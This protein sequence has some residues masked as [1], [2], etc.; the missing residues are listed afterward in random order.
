MVALSFGMVFLCS[1]VVVAVD[2]ATDATI[3]LIMQDTI[4]VLVLILYKELR[5]SLLHLDR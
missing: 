4:S 1:G 2:S 5:Y 3:R